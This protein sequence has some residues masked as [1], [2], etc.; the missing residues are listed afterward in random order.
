MLPNHIAHRRLV[1]FG[2]TRPYAAGSPAPY[3]ILATLFLMSTGHSAVAQAPATPP[4]AQPAINLGQTSFLDGEAG[5]GLLVEFIGD[6]VSADTL[7]GSRGEARDA[8]LDLRASTLL[9]HLAYVSNVHM[10]GARLGAESLVPIVDLR[11]SPTG[12][13]ASKATQIGDLTLAPFMQWSHISLLGR[14]LS[15][16]LATQFT[17]PTGSYRSDRTTNVGQNAWQVA[18]YL[19]ATW[20]AAPKLEV[21]GRATYAWSS[22]NRAPSPIYAASSVQAGNQLSV[23]LS[24]SYAIS[25]R[26]RLGVAGYIY[27]QTSDSRIDHREQPHFRQ[28]VDALG[29]GLRWQGGRFWLLCATYF[30]F[31]ARNRPEGVHTVLRLLRA[32]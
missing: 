18:P 4:V 25:A 17:A 24:T 3:R 8:D 29:P 11:Q 5:P 22:R 19:A 9:T 15:I 26:W 13:A 14:P 1:A 2:P 31:S 28:R 16:R 20:R 21:S 10:L 30:E 6:V 32:F 23:N 12:Q 27:R 7:R